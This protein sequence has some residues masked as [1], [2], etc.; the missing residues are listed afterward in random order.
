MAQNQQLN[1]IDIYSMKLHEVISL[2]EHGHYTTI[3]RVPGGW[4]YNNFTEHEDYR[5]SSVFVPYHEEFKLRTD[6]TYYDD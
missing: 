1:G 4:I 2:K 3:Y 5:I 6:L